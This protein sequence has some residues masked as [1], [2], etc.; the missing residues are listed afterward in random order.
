MKKRILMTMAFSW[1]LVAAWGMSESRAESLSPP[2]WSVGQTWSIET[3]SLQP[4]TDVQDTKWTAQWRFLV[5]AI[6][7]FEGSDCYRLV[8]T[9]LEQPEPKTTVWVDSRNFM[10]R[11]VD[12]QIPMPEGYVTVSE[13]YRANQPVPVIGPLSLIPLALPCFTTEGAKSDSEAET[14]EYNNSDFDGIKS[15]LPVSFLTTVSQ[16]VGTPDAESMK[17]FDASPWVKSIDTPDVLEVK[18]VTQNETVRQL[19]D[20]SAPWPVFSE[21]G[22]STARLLDIAVFGES[23]VSTERGIVPPAMN[24]LA[25]NAD[26]DNTKSVE[27]GG[28][29]EHGVASYKPWSGPWW[30]MNHGGL[31]VP[32]GKYDRITGHTSVAWERQ[33]NLTGNFRELP[34]WFGFCH[35]WAAASILEKE[36]KQVRNIAV[37][38]RRV[39][40]AIGDQKG[41]VTACHT[42]DLANS[43]GTRFNEGSDQAAFDDLSPE[44]LWKI[45]N[46]YVG[47]HGVPIVLDIVPGP[48]VWNHPVY[49]YEIKYRPSGDKYDGVMILYLADSAVALNYLGTQVFKKAYT[50]TFL[51]KDGC[52]VEGSG[53]WTGDSVND[54][55]DFAWS[56]YKSVAQNPEVKREKVVQLVYQQQETT[57]VPTPTQPTSPVV[58]TPPAPTTPSVATT[59]P[60]QQSPT[61][62]Q[63]ADFPVQLPSVEELV[64]LVGTRT[65]SFMS[66]VTVDRFDGAEYRPG[67]TFFLRMMS[68]R[69]GYLTLVLVDPEGDAALLIPQIRLTEEMV[70]KKEMTKIPVDTLSE[71]TSQNSLL[72][73]MQVFHVPSKEGRY[74]IKAFVTEKPIHFLSVPMQVSPAQV[75]QQT[76]QTQQNQ[77]VVQQTQVQVQVMTQSNQTQQQ[78]S[79]ALMQQDIKTL[80]GDFS[81]NEVIFYVNKQTNSSNLK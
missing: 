42:R 67:E 81:H 3:E 31:S 23:Q 38:N 65:S 51:M 78:S 6:D 21:N 33:H 58:S 49:E 63:V 76:L 56:P 43:W 19:W 74:R 11:R 1:L 16:T 12:S 77:Q 14:F 44:E 20:A 71:Q 2:N 62:V 9:P 80:F 61:Q 27:E 70:A 29:R 72:P 18:L 47:K 28:N 24:L 48:Q 64:A 26:D 39:S 25:D 4:Q 55:P 22:V 73:I 68:E 36:P 13:I 32:L 75:T 59:Q 66:E 8:I 40:L 34:E 69:A 7:E 35:A 46:Q 60:A 54:H 57:P 17:Q 50:F 15:D 30:P 5:E 53:Q 10:I 41:M 52:I 37:G 79:K 45:L